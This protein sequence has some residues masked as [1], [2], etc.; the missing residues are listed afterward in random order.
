MRDN[1]KSKTRYAMGQFAHPTDR[2]FIDEQHLASFLKRITSEEWFVMSFGQLQIAE[3]KILKQ[4]YVNIESGW[5]FIEVD[6]AWC[7]T[8]TVLRL[9]ARALKPPATSFSGAEF[10]AVLLYLVK[11]VLGDA[12]CAKL[13]THFRHQ[14]VDFRPNKHMDSVE[15]QIVLLKLLRK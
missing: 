1:Q 13:M 10:C 11:K 5:L 15:G 6:R 9:M 14:K 3:N 8:F 7:S 2:H 4:N 12:A